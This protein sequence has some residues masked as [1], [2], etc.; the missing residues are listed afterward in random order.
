[1]RHAML[2]RRDGA[3][4]VAGAFLF[5]TNAITGT[6]ETAIRVMEEGGYSRDVALH[7]AITIMR[8]T[9]G[10]AL[11]DQAEPNKRAE[12][13]RKRM[14]SGEGFRPQIDAER[15]PLVAEVMGRWVPLVFTSGVTPEQ[16]GERH[17]RHGLEL[18]MAGIRSVGAKGPRASD[19]AR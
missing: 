17:F 3:R 11:D 4:V 12:M 6:L 16:I 18:V 13:I 15:F 19:V 1:M 10:I 14:A 5:R 7:G 8:Y 2:S 9:M